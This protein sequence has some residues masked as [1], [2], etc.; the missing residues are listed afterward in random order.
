MPREPGPDQGRLVVVPLMGLRL[1]LAAI[2]L[3]AFLLG[4]LAVG[5]AGLWRL[6]AHA[7]RAIGGGA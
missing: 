1:L 3:A 7:V 5:L 4:M 2:G 6:A